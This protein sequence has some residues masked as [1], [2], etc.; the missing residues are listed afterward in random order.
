MPLRG[1]RRIAAALAANV[2][3]L[4]TAAIAAAQIPSG[5]PRPYPIY[6]DVPGYPAAA[7]AAG[8]TGV[9]RVEV[10]IDRGVVSQP[11]TTTPDVPHLSDAALT[12]A[13]ESRFG[14]W[15]CAGTPTTY[16][17]TYE[18][19][20]PRA[21]EEQPTVSMV[22]NGVVVTIPSMTMTA[23]PGTAYDAEGRPTPSLRPIWLTHPSYPV[24]ARA[25]R[26]QGMVEVRVTVGADGSVTSTDLSSTAPFLDEAALEAARETHFICRDCD[27]ATPQTYSLLYEFRFADGGPWA[28]GAPVVITP[29]QSRVTVELPEVLVSCGPTWPRTRSAKCLYLWRCGW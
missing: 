8:L 3:A 19:R 21:A 16:A 7:A 18:F 11:R 26:I 6:L 23:A 1:S 4:C 25:A 20:A 14:C 5:P 24:M 2:L 12:A 15:R 27:P 13:R 22:A 29:A 9:V 10:V 17:V 28:A